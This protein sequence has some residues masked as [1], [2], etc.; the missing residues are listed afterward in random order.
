MVWLTSRARP[1]R[2][3]RTNDK[4]KPAFAAANTDQVSI[5]SSAKNNPRPSTCPSESDPVFENITANLTLPYTLGA[6]LIKNG[7]KVTRG[8]LVSDAP[9]KTTG[10]TITMAGSEVS[11]PTV[12]V[13][14]K[15]DNPPLASGG[16]GKNVG[17]G[18]GEGAPSGSDNSDHKGSAAAIVAP[19]NN[20]FVASLGLVA[21]GFGIFL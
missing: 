6:D 15:A 21:L 1:S 12:E 4:L 11:D 8:K 2:P 16:H 13:L 9:K 17:G 18:N 3:A 14:F 20:A 5:P 10:F 7:V 19:I